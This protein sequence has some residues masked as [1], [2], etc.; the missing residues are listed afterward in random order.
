MQGS[1]HGTKEGIRGGSKVSWMVLCS[2]ASWLRQHGK[3]ARVDPGR[4]YTQG[5]YQLTTTDAK[6]KPATDR[7][8]TL[9][10]WKKQAD[11]AWKC[12]ADM[13]S[14]DLPATPQ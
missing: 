4:G 13:W 2:P 9:E 6:G 3:A 5:S 14:S 7:G 8:K 11:G 12:V 1:D 10:I